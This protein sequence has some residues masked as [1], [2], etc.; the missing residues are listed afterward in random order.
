MPS[1]PV[2]SANDSSS[3]VVECLERDGAVVVTGVID[4]GVR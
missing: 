2:V 4:R 3:K 1:I